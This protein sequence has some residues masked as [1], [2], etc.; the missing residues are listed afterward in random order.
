MKPHAIKITNSLIVAFK[1][2][3]R[4][5]EI[6]LEEEK[7]K[8]QVTKAEKKAMHIAADIDKL[9]VKRGQLERAVEMMEREFVECIRLADDKDD[10]AY[11][12]KGLG[13]KRKSTETKDSIEVVEKEIQKN[14]KK[15]R[16]SCCIRLFIFLVMFFSILFSH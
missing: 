1:S 11:V 3:R 10:M 4:R 5:Y 8:K 16:G 14:L 6:H 13:L 15:R 12:H 9:K 7:K 2:S